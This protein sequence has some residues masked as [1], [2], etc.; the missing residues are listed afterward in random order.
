M[1]IFPRGGSPTDARRLKNE[2]V[3]GIIRGYADGERVVWVD[4]NEKF[5]D[6]NGDTKWVMPDRLHPNG[7]G[8]EIW[9]DAVLPHFERICGKSAAN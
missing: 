3:N 5:L 7:K 8:Y 2:K 4:F 1:P 6:A 9:L